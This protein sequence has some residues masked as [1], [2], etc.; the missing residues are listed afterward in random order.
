VQGAYLRG[1]LQQERR[2]R[3]TRAHRSDR[4]RKTALR[5]GKESRTDRG[6]GRSKALRSRA[7][8]DGDKNVL[9]SR[10]RKW[11]FKGGKHASKKCSR[12]KKE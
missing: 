7:H 6:K 1:G 3:R 5:I 9:R 12:N 2:K 11:G 8:E 10:S 4:F